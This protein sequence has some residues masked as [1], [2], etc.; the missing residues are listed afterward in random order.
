MA[1]HFLTL[2]LWHFYLTFLDYGMINPE[3]V[4]VTLGEY[5]LVL[6]QELL[7]SPPHVGPHS[8]ADS[9]SNLGSTGV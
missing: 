1:V 6:G 3:N 8:A 5:I 2:K 9:N 7:H 4:L